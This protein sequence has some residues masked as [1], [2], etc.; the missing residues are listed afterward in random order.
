[1]VPGRK[2]KVCAVAE[3]RVLAFGEGEGLGGLCCRNL[4][5]LSVLVQL[6]QSIGS[7]RFQESV[8]WLPLWRWLG[9]DK[10]LISQGGEDVE[11]IALLP[12]A[13]DDGPRGLQTEA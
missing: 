4:M 10:A 12:V 9:H 7:Y 8:A 2:D 3:V 1:M 5:G 13:L 6:L 11:G